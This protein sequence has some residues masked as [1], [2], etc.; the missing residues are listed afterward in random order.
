MRAAL[1]WFIEHE[2]GEHALLLSSALLRFWYIRGYWSEG[3]RWLKKTLAL[4]PTTQSS[5]SAQAKA[6]YA[7]GELAFSQHDHVEAQHLLAQSVSL[8][9]ELGDEQGLAASL[10][11]L[12]FLRYI[13]GEPAS[14]Y[15]PLLEESQELCRRL[16]STWNLS[17]LMHDMGVIAFEQA[18]LPGAMN[19]CKESLALAQ[20]T[21]DRSL[22][23]TILNNLG[24]VAYLQG[25]F[26]RAADQQQAGLALARELGNKGL[27]GLALNN[28]GYYMFL[29]GN[30]IQAAPL[31]QEA[32][33]LA[34]ELGNKGLL[35]AALETLGSITL[36]QGDFVQ[37]SRFFKEG[38]TLSQLGN[39]V[40][41]G[42]LLIGLARVAAAQGQV[43]QAARL[44][45][46]AETQIDS[47]LSLTSFESASYKS[48]VESVRAQLGERAFADALVEGRT[49]GLQNILA[50]HVEIH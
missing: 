17:Q 5:K 30:Y 35:Q 44:L 39:K 27:I 9:R 45:G 42:L 22:M 15:I 25:D 49:L 21:G 10:G 8:Y 38:L 37:A 43:Q 4:L 23:G 36:A 20:E 11:R 18:D 19:L 26:T 32:L 50:A 7:A 33:M 13:Q 3:Q 12:G 1:Q 14:A 16:N 29:Q 40:Q 34:R 2:E 24:H 48:I 6:L 47:K 31:V 46:A 28:G 41:T